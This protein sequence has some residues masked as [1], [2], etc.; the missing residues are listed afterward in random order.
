MPSIQS[1]NDAPAGSCSRGPLRRHAAA[2]IASLLSLLLP[3]LL[4]HAAR[5]GLQAADDVA[6]RWPLVGVLLPAPLDQLPELRVHLGGTE[7]TLALVGHAARPF[8]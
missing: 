1:G 3:L 2:S 8:L 5:E 7:G 4:L 6:H